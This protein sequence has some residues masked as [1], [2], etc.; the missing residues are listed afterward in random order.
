MSKMDQERQDPDNQDQHPHKYVY[1]VP[2]SYKEPENCEE[3]AKQ[4]PAYV[5]KDKKE[6]FYKRNYC[7]QDRILHFY[8]KFGFNFCGLD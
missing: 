5:Q 8:L 6:L 4:N 2:Q 3:Y 7:K 1:M